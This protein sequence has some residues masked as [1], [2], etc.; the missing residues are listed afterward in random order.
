MTSHVAFK[1]RLLFGM[2][3]IL[4]PWTDEEA[5]LS[6]FEIAV[7]IHKDNVTDDTLDGDQVHGVHVSL[8]VKSIPETFLPTMRTDK[9]L[10]GITSTDRNMVSLH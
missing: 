5:I 2:E 9:L 7:L 4:S 6:M 10:D 3:G 1:P 8:Q